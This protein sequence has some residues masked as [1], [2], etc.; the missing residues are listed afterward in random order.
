MMKQLI[1]VISGLGLG[2]VAGCSVIVDGE[3]ANRMGEDAGPSGETCSFDA[4]CISFDPFNC[5]RVCGDE[6]FCVD[7]PTAPD[8]TRC[9]MSMAASMHCVAGECVMRTC[10]DGYVDRAATPPEFCD[11]GDDT[12][13]DDGCHMCT[14][15]CA[16]PAPA[17]CSDDDPCNGQESCG[18]VGGMMVC[19][20]TQGLA[21]DTACPGGTCQQGTCTP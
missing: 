11:D 3:L 18:D 20:S 10:G 14:R 21:D 8:G 6:G 5:N 7:G 13:P 9:G 16:P 12:N 2:L 15:S 17:N 1:L 4:Q 19:R